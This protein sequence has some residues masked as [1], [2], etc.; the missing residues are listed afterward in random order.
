MNANT[1]TAKPTNT[2]QKPEE[3]KKTSVAIVAAI[4]ALSTVISLF[5]GASFYKSETE[6][7]IN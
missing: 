1:K 4:F 2:A 3:K 6:K 7:F 5:Y